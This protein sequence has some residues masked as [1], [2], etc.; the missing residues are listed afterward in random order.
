MSGTEEVTLDGFPIRINPRSIAWDFSL[1]TSVKDTIGGRVIQVYGVSLGDLVVQGQCNL[2]DYRSLSNKVR[3]VAEGQAPTQ[4]NQIP[5]PVRFS[6]GTRGWDFWVF[7]KSFGALEESNANIAPQW[8]LTL[9]IDQ[10]NSEIVSVA[11]EASQTAYIRRISQGLGW[12]QTSWNGPMGLDDLQ[13]ILKGQTIQGFLFDKWGQ[14]G[15]PTGSGG[16]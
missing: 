6:W 13:A 11:K 7:V 12:T 1:K 14:V 9:F 4:T 8:N 3:S 16:K 5:S 2:A 10:D 15:Q